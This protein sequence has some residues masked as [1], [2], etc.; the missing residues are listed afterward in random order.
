MA[1][2]NLGRIKGDKGDVGDVG[3]RGDI[4]PT[5]P[6]G[7]DGYT[8]TLSIE[9]VVTVDSDM[10]ANAH[11]DS[12]DP[13]MPK[14]T[15][16]IPRGADGQDAHGDMERSVYDTEGKRT[17]FYEFAAKLFSDALKKEGGNLT[18]KL[19][20]HCSQTNEK[21]VRNISFASAFPENAGEGDICFIYPE[22]SMISIY[23]QPEGST[24]LIEENGQ[25]EE[26]ILVAKDYHGGGNVTL[27]RKYLLDNAE[28]YDYH[29]R[30]TY[31][32][33]DMDVY[34]E[35]FFLK[36]FSKRIIKYLVWAELEANKKR[37]CFIPSAAELSSF[38]YFKANGCDATKK[39]Q[40]E[41]V[42]YVARDTNN[43]REALC[44]GSG[45]VRYFLSQASAFNIR[46]FIVLSGSLKTEN[47]INDNEY[48]VRIIESDE[49]VYVYENGVWKGL[50]L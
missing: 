49:G 3:P 5:G 21:C 48:A 7:T 13:A 47:M 19:V 29:Q 12:Q 28:C 17:D 1:S 42:G 6:R 20:A 46:P 27:A 41:K 4:G 14:L 34:L 32:M 38:E 18:G 11:I 39:N 8:P 45:G 10:D 26:Y 31:F 37:R 2:L 25:D 24:V 9:K 35:T 15:L 33:S 36:G 50:S 30:N 23:E 44:I 43:S 22:E 16:Y 40:N